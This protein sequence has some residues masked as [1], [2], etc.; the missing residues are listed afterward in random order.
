MIVWGWAAKKIG[1][2]DVKG[3]CPSCK[4]ATLVLVGWQR[5]F[6]VFWIPTIPLKKTSHVHCITCN[7]SYSP[8]GFSERIHFKTP[9]W[10]F[11][12]LILLGTLFSLIFLNLIWKNVKYLI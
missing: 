9:W 7:A 1:T 8:E 5:T 11:S 10:A 12:G 3:V 2:H 4:N 6:D